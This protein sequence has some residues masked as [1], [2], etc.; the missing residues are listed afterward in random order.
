MG[1]GLLFLG[2]TLILCMSGYGVL[3]S[4]VGY[5]VCMYACLKLSEY[6]DKFK[7][8]AWVFGGVGVISMMQSMLHLTV[9][10]NGNTLLSDFAEWSQ[11]AGEL[12]FYAGQWMI[13]PALTSIASDTGRKKTVFACRRNKVLFILMFGLY[14]AANILIYTGW[15]YSRYCLVYAVASRF[16]VLILNMISVFSCYMWICAEGQEEEELERASKLNESVNSFFGKKRSETR[17]TSRESKQTKRRKK[18]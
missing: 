13:L 2:F 5:F 4:F 15:E 12:A 8:A 17:K 6:E 1:F 18:K 11:P 9:L 16:I 3:P 7:T 14:V 10:L